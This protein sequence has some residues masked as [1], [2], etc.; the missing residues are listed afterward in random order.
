[1]IKQQ[2][3]DD[4]NIIDNFFYG[5]DLNE[6]KFQ[7]PFKKH[8]KI[9]LEDREDLKAFIEYLFHWIEKLQYNINREA[10]KLSSLS[11][12]KADRNGYLTGEETLPFLQK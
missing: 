1:M 2:Y 9:N 4:Y 6:A 3:D 10:A 11:S 7:H 5:R 12:G 8:E